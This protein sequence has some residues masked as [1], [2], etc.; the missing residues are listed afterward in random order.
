MGR[1]PLKKEGIERAALELF[2]EKGVD[3]TSIRDIA[4]RAGATEGAMYRHHRSKDDLVR[5][6]FFRHYASFARLI[7]EFSATR[8]PFAEII[9]RLVHAFFEFYDRDPAIF[10]FV[11]LVRHHLLEEVRADDSN[12]VEVLARFVNDAAMRGEIRVEDPAL[13]TQL[14]LGMVMQPPVAM[15]YGRLKGPLALHSPEVARQ[16]LAV[17]GIMTHAP[18]G[19]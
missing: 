9:P 10:Q 11:M 6:L 13:T 3:G 2:V 7:V 5:A 16:C 1:P 8:Q 15:Q 14:L 12:P 19:D 18:Q 17:C 4:E